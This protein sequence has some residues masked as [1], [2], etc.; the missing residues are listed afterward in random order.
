MRNIDTI[1]KDIN[2]TF[3][4]VGKQRTKLRDLV[5]EA[6][7]VLESLDD[8][9]VSVAEAVSNLEQVKFDLDAVSKW[10]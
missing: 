10:L 5:S 9:Q 3:I 4:E 6:E 7:D 8:L 1:I 2:A